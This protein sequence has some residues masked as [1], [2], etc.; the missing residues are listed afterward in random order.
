MVLLNINLYVSR[1][2]HM[3]KDV[4]VGDKVWS[5]VNGWGKVYYIYDHNNF[6]TYI[7]VE[8]RDCYT[9]YDVNGKAE[10]NEMPSLFWDEV[11]IEAPP[12]PKKKIKKWKWVVRIANAVGCDTYHI[13]LKYTNSAKEA[14]ECYLNGEVVQRID[15]SMIEVEED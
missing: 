14:K 13:T 7:K 1:R 5:V 12:K 11:K 9:C 10:F 2:I 4:K 6:N 3:F 15:D 8:F